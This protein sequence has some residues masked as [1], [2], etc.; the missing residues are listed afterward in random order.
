[1]KRNFQRACE[2]QHIV[3]PLKHIKANQRLKHIHTKNFSKK[4]KILLTTGLISI[5]LISLFIFLQTQI[6]QNI[7]TSA[8]TPNT[9]ESPSTPS[10]GPQN[11]T[12]PSGST[13]A[14]TNDPESDKIVKEPGFLE[15]LQTVNKTTW[16]AIASTAWNYFK[17]DT[18]VNRETGLPFSGVGAP[19]FT[20]WDLGTYIQAV[21]DAEK[22]GLINRT[23][24]WG[25]NERINKILYW[26]E[27]RDL[28][29]GSNPY[30]FY[31]TDTGKVS[32][33]ESNKMPDDYIDIADTGRLFVAL[34][35]LRKYSE[36]TTRIENIT[37]HGQD[38]NRTNYIKLIPTI[39][40]LVES[41][42]STYA[43]YIASGF[44]AFWPELKASPGK[45]LDN[46]FSAEYI[47]VSGN[48]RLPKAAISCEPLLCAFFEIENNDPRLTTLVNLT[49]SAHEAHYNITK[50]FRAFGEGPGSTSS[51][52]GWQWEWVML[53]DGRAWIVLD[54]KQN[55]VTASPMVYTKIAYSFLAI[56]D[57]NFTRSL[58]L[59]IDQPT[60]ELAEGFG[61][62]YDEDG[63]SRYGAGSLTN[64]LIIG[65]ARY[66]LEQHL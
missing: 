22:I 46:I 8:T 9:S 38:Y 30:W 37:L 43:Y 58:C 17:P 5:I 25:F 32:K 20:D 15:T 26:L 64:G 19:G 61:H 31:R 51:G 6:P 16:Q 53:A 45:V 41:D 35:N 4:T 2:P 54:D 28:N 29:N 14:L 49:Y 65:A 59:F 13:N 10:S 48:V 27:T 36:Y 44:A 18:G 3:Y 11:N 23:E 33:D 47:T 42:S 1:M 55:A 60:H 7:D 21:I 24:P 56:Y 62:G 66:Y 52:I 34:N 12:N 40:P 63:K 39:K 57:N 50:K